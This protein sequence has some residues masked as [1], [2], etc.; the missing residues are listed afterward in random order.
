MERVRASV[1]HDTLALAESGEVYSS[2]CMAVK[3][4]VWP[5]HAYNTGTG[6]V[7]FSPTRQTLLAPSEKRREMFGD[8]HEG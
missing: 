2:S 3:W 6:H 8:S 7:G 5:Q 1:G 4:H